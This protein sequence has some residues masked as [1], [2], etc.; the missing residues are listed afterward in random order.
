MDGPKHVSN[1]FGLSNHQI[2]SKYFD[3][4]E[5][6]KF[7]QDWKLRHAFLKRMKVADVASKDGLDDLIQKMVP[8][9]NMSLL[10]NKKRAY[11]LAMQELKD[12][13]HYKDVDAIKNF[14]PSKVDAIASLH[15]EVQHPKNGLKALSALQK[16]MQTEEPETRTRRWLHDPHAN[17]PHAD[18]RGWNDP[19]AND[20]H[21]DTRGLTFSRPSSSSSLRSSSSW[22]S[23]SSKHSTNSSASKSNTTSHGKSAH[24]SSTSSLIPHSSVRSNS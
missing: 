11:E 7:V 22:Y 3:T 14:H 24:R 9:G 20:P 23:D 19:Y 16:H 17:D 8:T 15:P 12:S 2:H 18:T 13:G 1:Y 5:Y 10:Y 6:Q 4:H 21:A